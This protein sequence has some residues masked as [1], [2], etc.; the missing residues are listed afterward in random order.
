MKRVTDIMLRERFGVP[1]ND[2][3]EGIHRPSGREVVIQLDLSDD[4]A[5]TPEP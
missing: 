2:E 1:H 5:I 3:T 4:D